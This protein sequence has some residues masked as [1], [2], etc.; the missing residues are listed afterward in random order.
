MD[1]QEPTKRVLITGAFGRLGRNL[2]KKAQSRGWQLICT[3]L[4]SATT[5]QEVEHWRNQGIEVI[6]GDLRNAGFIEDLIQNKTSNLD[7]VIHVAA[8]VPPIPDIDST[9]SFEVNVIAT[10]KLLKALEKLVQPPFFIF[11]STYNVYGVPLSN[12]SVKSAS[13][14]VAASDAYSKHKIEAEQLIK[15]CELPW[16]I[17]RVC[18][19]LDAKSTSRT[20]K[21]LM[22]LAFEMSPDLPS[23]CIHTDDAAL[24]LC[25]LVTKQQQANHK[26]LLIGGGLSCRVTH[27]DLMNVFFQAWGLKIEPTVFGRDRH[28]CHWLD[29]K[30]SQTLLQYQQHSYK[31][32]C[33]QA[34]NRFKR[35]RVFIRPLSFLLSPIANW[36]IKK[37]LRKSSWL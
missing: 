23:E 17:A 16:S 26:T 14:E 21:K 11:T 36:Y 37:F 35:A 15:N 24:A 4:E 22:C 7:A 9:L 25:N 30:E 29:T 8:V 31:D 13:D 34:N 27:Y 19:V 6:L 1:L 10:S 32:I 12:H 5:A 2:T 18:A 33:Q 20:S 28:A 3:D